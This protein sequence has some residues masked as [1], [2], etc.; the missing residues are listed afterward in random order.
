MVAGQ[1]RGLLPRSPREL[2]L[3]RAVYRYI[4]DGQ[5]K[6]LGEAVLNVCEAPDVLNTHFIVPL[7]LGTLD[8]VPDVPSASWQWQRVRNDKGHGKGKNLCGSTTQRSELQVC[9]CVLNHSAMGWGSARLAVGRQLQGRMLRAIRACGH[10]DLGRKLRCFVS[11]CLDSR[12]LAFKLAA[13][14]VSDASG[15]N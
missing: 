2:E 3:R 4:R 14:Q 11:L 7:T 13:G 9:S 15:M 12:A 10:E 8:D 1:F 5:R 6:C